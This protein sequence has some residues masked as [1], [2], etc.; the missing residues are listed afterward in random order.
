MFEETSGTPNTMAAA[1]LPRD[2]PTLY[3]H[4]GVSPDPTTGAILA[5]IYQ[6]TT[7]VQP[8]VEKYLEKGY[9]YSRSG[10]PTVRALERRLRAVE[11]GADASC[12]STGMATTIAVSGEGL[13]SSSSRSLIAAAASCA[14]AADSSLGAHHFPQCWRPLHHA[15]VSIRGNL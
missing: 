12:F 8:S 13:R 11:G 3:V 15:Q 1:S 2:D 7:Y 6:S 5:P 14:V 4:E 10:N 9:S